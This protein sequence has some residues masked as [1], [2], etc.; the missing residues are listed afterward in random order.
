ME[1]PFIK[2]DPLETGNLCFFCKSSAGDIGPTRQH[3]ISVFRNGSRSVEE[4]SRIHV[5]SRFQRTKNVA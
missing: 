4:T 2:F 5:L 1:S 3:A